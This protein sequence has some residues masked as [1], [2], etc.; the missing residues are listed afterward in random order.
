MAIRHN[1]DADSVERTANV[2]DDTAFTASCWI[3]RVNDRVG[4]E[5]LIALD[6][7]VNGLSVIVVDEDTNAI[8]LFNLATGSTQ[9]YATPATA[10]WYFVAMTCAGT[11]ANAQKGYVAAATET[12]LTTAS[13]T[14]EAAHTPSGLY[15]G[16]HSLDS[17]EW[18]DGR[19]AAIKVW[20]A[21]LTQAELEQERWCY[22]PART[23][24]LNLWAPMI[25]PVVADNVT[26]F[27]GNGRNLTFTNIGA[28]E[29]GPPI[30][31]GAS[32]IIFPIV[33]AAAGD[34]VPVCWQQYRL[35][36]AA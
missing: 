2:P 7:G 15:F 33:S 12:A 5:S 19:I 1:S 17:G 22:R 9:V 8:K 20:D 11:G 31:W 34:A 29:D 10:T 3:Y 25:N 23:A 24:N 14:G 30:G 21:V 32:P 28:V 16:R 26:D 13:Q 18:L 36:R 35:R 27:S 4:Q 6:E